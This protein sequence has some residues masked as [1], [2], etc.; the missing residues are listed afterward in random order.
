LVLFT[1][2]YRDA[3]S[4]KHRKQVNHTLTGYIL[5]FIVC[6]KLIIIIIIQKYLTLSKLKVAYGLRKEKPSQPSH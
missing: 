4:T 5:S 3:Q 1:K 2:L 6:H